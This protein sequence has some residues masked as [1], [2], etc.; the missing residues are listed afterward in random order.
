VKALKFDS[1][2]ALFTDF[3]EFTKL[4]EQREPEKLVESID[5][6]FKKFDEITTKYGLEKIKTIGDSYMCAGGLPTVTQT[7]PRNVIK[8]AKEM[9]DRVNEELIA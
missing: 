8:A 3:K 5:F 6:Y 4:A 1:D 7:H 9:I 2:T